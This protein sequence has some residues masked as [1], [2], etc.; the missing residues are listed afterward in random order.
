MTEGA[1]PASLPPESSPP[2]TDDDPTF[3]FLV[4]TWNDIPHLELPPIFLAEPT[5]VRYRRI[6]ADEADY[7]NEHN[8]PT[9]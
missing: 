4:A 6:S 3:G 2:P 8:N 9:I 5:D 7:R 1:A